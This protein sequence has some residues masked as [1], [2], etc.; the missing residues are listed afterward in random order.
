M[1][2]PT[3]SLRW[4]AVMAWRDSRRQRKRL[5]LYMTAISLGTAALVSI[6]SFGDNLRDGIHN[7]AQSLLGADLM[8]RARDTIP[9]DLEATFANFDAEKAR[10]AEFASMALFPQSEAAGR[11]AFTRLCIVRAMR[12]GFPWY[13]D[14]ITQ[15]AEALSGF[16]A[17][18]GVLMDESLMIQAGAKPGDSVQVGGATFTLLGAILEIPGES[19]ASGMFAPRVYIPYAEM[20][21]AGMLN[22]AFRVRYK[23]YFKFAERDAQKAAEEALKPHIKAYN[24]RKETNASRAARVERNLDGVIKFLNIV[25]FM[26]LFLG[27]IGVAG[28]VHGYI[29][30]KL[31]TAAV[32]RCLGLLP[33]DVM[34]IYLMQVSALALIGAIIG[35]VLGVGVQTGLPQVLGDFLPVD[36]DVAVSWPGIA[37]GLA[38]G[39]ITA[40]IFAMF[41]LLDV[42]RVAPLAALRSASTG[43]KPQRDPWRWL[44]YLLI[45]AGVSAFAFTHSQNWTHGL[46]LTVAFFVAFGLLTALAFGL[47]AMVRK[48]LPAM[49]PYVIRQG[50]CNLY[51]PNNQTRLLM[52]CL[53]LSTFLLTTLYLTQHNLIDQFSRKSTIHKPNLILINV[54]PDQREAISAFLESREMPT[55]DMIPIVPMRLKAVNETSIDELQAAAK[56][57]GK[58]K[59]RHRRWALRHNYRST[60]RAETVD[61]E[62]ILRGEWVSSYDGEGPIPVSLEE[63]IAG[64]LKVDVGDSLTLEIGEGEQTVTIT[65]IRKVDWYRLE[66]NF[67]MVFPPGSIDGADSNTVV[68]TRAADAEANARFQVDVVAEFA[69]VTVL[70]VAMALRS[71]DSFLN[72]AMFAVRF[73]AW[74]SLI[75]GIVVLISSLSVSRYQ[76]LRETMLLRTLGAARRQLLIIAASEFVLLGSLAAVAGVGMAVLGSWGLAHFMFQAPFLLDGWSLLAAWAG[77]TALTLGIGMMNSIGLSRVNPRELA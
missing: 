48:F 53:G 65:S 73:M 67:Y 13:G 33:R 39:V 18:D 66:P 35:A 54:Q 72:K 55:M 20:E 36:V 42:R 17:G 52:V 23:A 38:T 61:S 4:L 34:A 2:E 40:M 70:D 74:F 47:M 69:N 3:R 75:T 63:S 60:W 16:R 57:K 21:A 9:D 5:L 45:V 29:R 32:L 62:E 8:V 77:V 31:R 1:A 12:G 43:G 7:Q 49:L 15:P 56:A 50:L 68:T 46:A 10:L 41:P 30:Q 22:F 71:I 44:L 76:R 26:A 28:A 19:D 25:G 24:L 37:Q 6:T 14:F 58:G 59:G 27:G 11:S 51:R 64:E